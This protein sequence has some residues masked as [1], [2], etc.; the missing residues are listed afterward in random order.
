MLS[1][2]QPCPSGCVVKSIT[3]ALVGSDARTRW[4]VRVFADEAPNAFALPGGKVGVNTGLLRVASNQHQLAAVIGHEIAHVLEGHSNERVSQGM[5]AQSA[6]SAVEAAVDAGNPMHGQMLGLLGAGVQVGV[7]LPFGREHENEADLLGLEHMARAGFDPRESVG[8]WRNMAAAGKGQ[9][10]EFLSTH[11]SHGTR[12]QNL[13]RHMSR[14]ML[15]HE[16]AMARGLRPRPLGR[17]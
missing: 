9:P 14:A 5:L 16:K 10:P 8:L 2:P 11:P 15:L 17:N 1:R 12:I 6:M 7:L 13:T 4:E 3:G